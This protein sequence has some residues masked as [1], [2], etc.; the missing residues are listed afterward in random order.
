MITLVFST[1]RPEVLPAVEDLMVAHDLVVLEE[2]PHPQFQA[3]LSGRVGIEEYLEATDYEFP[4]FARACCRL[5]RRLHGAGIRILQVE[6][7]LEKLAELHDFFADG[8]TA[9]MLDPRDAITQVYRAERRA[10][11]AL[12]HYY[13]VSV[14]EPFDQVVEAVKVFAKADAARIR[15]RDRLR[16]EALAKAAEDVPRIYVE[17][18]YIHWALYTHLKGKIREPARMRAVWPLAARARRLLGRKQV[19]GPGDLLTL[20]YVFRPN[21][22]GKDADVLAAKSLIYVKLLEKKEMVPG[23]GETPHLEDEAKAWLAVRSLTYEDCR[24][25]WPQVRKSSSSGAREAVRRF[26]DGRG[27]GK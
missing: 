10:S 25:L 27:T 14:T 1:H 23:R 13:R 24:L 9:H 6:P 8:G 17:A 26:L 7:Y 16:A 22:N 5:Y 3:M 20:R 18:G 15:L 21:W 2:P 4:V 11:G 19:L 12:L